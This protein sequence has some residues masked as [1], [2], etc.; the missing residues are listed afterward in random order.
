[1]PEVDR[2]LLANDLTSL[3]AEGFMR[4]VSGDLYQDVY[5]HVIDCD[6][7]TIV[8]DGSDRAVAFMAVS[9]KDFGGLR[10]YHLEGIIVSQ[11]LQGNGFSALLLSNDLRECG[12][13]VLTFHTQSRLM[14]KLGLKVANYDRS[15]ATQVAESVGTR[16][17]VELADGPIDKGRY[18]GVS[19]YGD[20]QRFDSFAIKRLGF[21]YQDGD[22]IVFAGRIV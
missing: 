12:A 16:N 10:V 21:S 19:L 9:L 18:G 22:A 15:L 11:R 8:R 6:R 1:M 17:L 3:A 13:D 7:L 20:I 4:Q 14:E 2:Q 5:H